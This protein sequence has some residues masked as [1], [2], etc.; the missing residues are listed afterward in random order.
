MVKKRKADH[1]SGSDASSELNDTSPDGS[2]APEKSVSAPT[3]QKKKSKS[4]KSA[5]ADEQD[6]LPQVPRKPLSAAEA[7]K[8]A[9][10]ETITVPEPS[11]RKPVS[12]VEAR[13]RALEASTRL[14]DAGQSDDSLEDFEPDYL[15][16]PEDG[17]DSSSPVNASSQPRDDFQNSVY[18][19]PTVELS[20]WTPKHGNVIKNS[21]SGMTIRLA[22]GETLA[23][24][25]I[26]D[27]FVKRG[28]IT[29][30]GAILRA[31]PSAQAYRVFAPASHALPVVQCLS[32]DGA[33]VELKSVTCELDSLEK[34]SPLQGRLWKAADTPDPSFLKNHKKRWSFENIHRLSD[35]ALSRPLYHLEIPPKWHQA[36]DKVCSA[37][38]KSRSDFH[39][40][41]FI[42][43]PKNT[44][45]S[46]FVRM[47]LNR[48][49][50]IDREA[51]KTDDHSIFLL[52][53][54][55]GQ[56]EYSP[57]GQISLV[58]LRQPIFGP[59]FTHP[60]ANTGSHQRTVRAHYI[61][62]NS[63]KDNP[64]HLIECA[65]DLMTHYQKHLTFGNTHGPVIINSPGWIIGT[66][67]H[68][69]TSL[70]ARL[71]VTDV[72]YTTD[73]PGRSLDAL[74]AAS[75]SASVPRF[76]IIPSQL[77]GNLSARTAAEFRDMQMLSYFHLGAPTQGS[78]HQSWDPT[79]LTARKPYA[80]SYAAPDTP[81]RDFL[82][83]MPF[84][85]APPHS[86]LATLLN[87]SIVGIVVLTSTATIDAS[88]ISILRTPA[89]N[90]PYVSPGAHFGH[91][92]PFSPQ[93]AHLIALGLVRSIDAAAQTLHVLV[94]AAC[95]HL[96]EDLVPERTLL[97][98]G[99]G[100]DT[101]GWAY[102]E[103]LHAAEARKRASGSSAE[104]SEMDVDVEER[105]WVQRLDGGEVLGKKRRLRRFVK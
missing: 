57:P 104:D 97:V 6:V 7:R 55:P 48:M 102:L 85:E 3:R 90:I 52:D 41:V 79:P 67:L 58:E 68:I 89:E 30:Y 71:S 81:A 86:T 76:H 40:R 99:T 53:L 98:L 19:P 18:P 28:V 8:K 27:V 12:A 17:G 87:G 47:L 103:D 39:E 4:Q 51:M 21:A 14:P 24:I 59:P 10:V 29:L 96:V 54:D 32:P 88:P 33:E 25:G 101:P 35:D 70:I 60:S 20:S 77:S 62:A 9:A 105:P 69:L 31:G 42:C 83:V 16:R 23:N 43:G 38:S 44:G 50:T 100:M 34:L 61:G 15:P 80:L 5:V 36:I 74:Q 82:A 94:P 72:I 11:V 75:A 37:S 49:F 2:P 95:E 13:R 22:G 78:P 93:Q 92:E 73:E 65:V 66:G 46:T 56:P 91:L 84:G 26:Y 45:K 64:E 1:H 63:P